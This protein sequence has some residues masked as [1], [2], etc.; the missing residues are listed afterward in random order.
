MLTL[1]LAIGIGALV[2]LT[3]VVLLV[4]RRVVISRN[5]VDMSVRLSSAIP[6]RGWAIGM[7][8]FVGP[9]LRW[10]RM[11]SL[12]PRPRRV[13]SRPRLR[14]LS[15]RPPDGTEIL[16]MPADNVIVRCV[17][18]A[19]R[20][21]PS[22]GRLWPRGSRSQS[23]PAGSSGLP[24]AGSG[25]GAT[26]RVDRDLVEIALAESTLTGFLSWLEAG[27]PGASSSSPD[28]VAR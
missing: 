22:R 5:A 14:V 19:D 7:A 25:F 10:Y 12:S 4:V 16:A 6:G 11:F 9:E 8:R 2:V 27:P 15:K 3:G 18:R 26:D 17:M 23:A 21:S 28:T 13:F 20:I 24:E 1:M